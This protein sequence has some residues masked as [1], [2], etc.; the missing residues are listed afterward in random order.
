MMTTTAPS[1][2]ALK[3]PLPLWNPKGLYYGVT[4]F[5]FSTAGRLSDGIDLGH[6]YGFDSGVMLEY[7]YRN[8]SNG[9]FGVGKLIDRVYLNAPGWKGIRNRGKLLTENLQAVIVEEHVRKQRPLTIVDLACG[10]GRYVLD[11]LDGL[12]EHIAVNAVL[13]DYREENVRSAQNLADEMGVKVTTEQADAFSNADLAGLIELQPDIIIVSGLHEIIDDNALV[14][15]HF[16]QISALLEIGGRLVYTIQPEHPQ[17][18]LIARVLPSHTGELWVM[19]LRPA[20][21][22]KLWAE[23][24]GFQIDQKQ[25]EEQNIFGVVTATKIQG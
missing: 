8:Q 25:M 20:T 19:R 6:R 14:R 22:T 9:K 23:F 12:P 16:R 11:A 10:G 1:F 13:R 5:L 21:T 7:V 2:E 17:H 18:E 24:A 15:N 4:R 3:K